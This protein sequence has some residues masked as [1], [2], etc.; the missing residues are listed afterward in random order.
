MDE[1]NVSIKLIRLG[2]G[3][4][5]GIDFTNDFYY[6]PFQLLSSGIERLMKCTICLG[7]YDDHGM[8]PPLK[9][10]KG[11]GHKLLE[12]KNTILKHY[13]VKD[14][15]QG[16]REDFKFLSEDDNISILLKFLSEFGDTGRYHNLDVVTG[17]KNKGIDVQRLWQKYE[18]EVMIK[19]KEDLEAFFKT[20]TLEEKKK[21]VIYKFVGDLERFVRAIC[22]QYTLGKISE[23]RIQFRV[24]VIGFA[25]L[26]DHELSK[27]EY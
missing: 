10:I 6:L 7:Y 2:L 19:D 17:A 4:L 25:I 15:P 16:L 1:L 9:I 18:T 12:L 21:N 23:K 11:K 20:A 5:Q 26:S 3:E 8:Y 14:T 24:P 13:F 22:R 27:Q